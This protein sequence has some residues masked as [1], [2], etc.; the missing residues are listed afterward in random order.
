MQTDALTIF[1]KGAQAYLDMLPRLEALA[2]NTQHTVQAVKA[3]TE[4]IKHGV[5]EI[6]QWIPRTVKSNP[7]S[8]EEEMLAAYRKL[9]DQLGQREF[10]QLL[11]T[12]PDSLSIYRAQCIARWAQPRFAIDKQF[13]PLTLLLDH[14]DEH[15]GERYQKTRNTMICV[16]FSPQWT[17]QP[18]L[19]LL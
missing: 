16:I 17:A 11:D 10:K 4:E 8:S 6:L 2:L 13:T 14:G 5:S 19:S 7:E 3:D 1:Q 18:N 9:L 15:E 12:V